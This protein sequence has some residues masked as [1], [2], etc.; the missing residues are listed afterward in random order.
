MPKTL[1]IH[2][3]FPKSGTT[4]LQ[5]AL[6]ENQ[7]LLLSEGI[8][9]PGSTG[10]AHHRLVAGLVNR[11]VGWGKVRNNLD[12]WNGFVENLSTF[13]APRVLISSEFLTAAKYEEIK[14]IKSSFSDCNIKIIFTL[15]P[16]ADMVPSY[17]QQ[18]LKKGSVLTFLEWINSKFFLPSGN[19]HENPKLLN[20]PRVLKNWVKVFESENVYLLISDSSDKD[21]LYQNFAKALDI[22]DLPP[23]KNARF[24]RSL[25]VRESE[26]L[27]LINVSVKDKWD[28]PSYNRIVRERF[29]K[30]LTNTPSTKSESRHS[31]PVFM[32]DHIEK[33]A[34]QAIVEI[35]KLGLVVYGDLNS[36]ARADA[37]IH[38][39]YETDLKIAKDESQI[40]LKQLNKE[41]K[42]DR[43]ISKRIYARV[44]RV[45]K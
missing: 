8:Y 3:G 36:I 24:N 32:I 13:D 25:T 17:Y 19:L 15:R 22:P 43:K 16:L 28:W 5:A 14:K 20:H 39:S 35:E 31:I 40:H 30:R 18:S 45:I 1:Y 6:R 12:Q 29:V 33:V 38:H 9:Y 26:I 4:A 11:R 21:L 34:K 10:N 7:D 23:A 2:A 41:Y 44:K 27:R 42:S 37:K